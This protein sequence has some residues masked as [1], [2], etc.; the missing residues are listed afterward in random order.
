MFL[1]QQWQDSNVSRDVSVIKMDPNLTL[2]HVTHNT[3][4]ILLHQHIAYPPPSWKDV[5]ALPSS[6][7][8]ETCQLA[9]V[10]ISSIVEK[11]LRYMGGI[12]NSQFAFCAFA[13]AR[14]LLVHWRSDATN[15]LAPEFFTLLQSL[16]DMSSRWR[17]YYTPTTNPESVSSQQ[18]A[19]NR[20]KKLDLACRYA[21]QLSDLHARCVGDAEFSRARYSGILSEASLEGFLQNNV[22]SPSPDRQSTTSYHGYGAASVNSFQA[23]VPANRE[24]L[25]QNHHVRSASMN[26]ELDRRYQAVPQHEIPAAQRQ[27]ARPRPSIGGYERQGTRF[28]AEEVSPRAQFGGIQSP[29]AAVHQPAPSMMSSAASGL[30]P[31]GMDHRLAPPRPIIH[32]EDELTAMSQMLLENQFLEMDRVIRLDGTDFYYDTGGGAGLMS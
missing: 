17:G 30:V 24:P 12:V 8:A 23:H 25:P 28:T 18:D 7:S 15:T 19:L 29:A 21:T 22:A 3:S 31:M 5:V 32:E 20:Y 1:P 6:C 4:M 9:A 13:A 2:A 16:Q 10:E 14:V 26:S 27:P 11:Y